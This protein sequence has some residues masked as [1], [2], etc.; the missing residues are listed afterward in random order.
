MPGEVRHDRSTDALTH[1]KIRMHFCAIHTSMA[2][3]Y[4][5]TVVQRCVAWPWAF[6][7]EAVFA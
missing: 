1:I 3:Q 6:W 7:P 4:T 5:V 2:Q